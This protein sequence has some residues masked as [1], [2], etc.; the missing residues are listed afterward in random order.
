MTTTIIRNDTN[1][2]LLDRLICND[3]TLRHVSIRLNLSTRIR[4][5]HF[6][7]HNNHNIIPTGHHQHNPEQHPEQQQQQ[8]VSSSSTTTHPHVYYVSSIQEMIETVQT[9][10]P[11]KYVEEFEFCIPNNN[12][13][14]ID[15]D[16]DDEEEQDDPYSH[17][18]L[19]MMDV[20]NNTYTDDF[21]FLDIS[22]PIY[23]NKSSNTDSNNLDVVNDNNNI[24][25][26]TT[27]IHQQNQMDEVVDTSNHVG[28]HQDE[29][30]NET[31]G[32]SLSPSSS[33]ALIITPTS[34]KNNMK[35]DE[36]NNVRE[37][38]QMNQ[39]LTK[40]IISN[41]S[42][43]Y[44]DIWKALCDGILFNQSIEELVIGDI[45][46]LN[47]YQN[48]L[49]TN[50]C[51]IIGNLLYQ[52]DHIKKVTFKGLVIHNSKA[53]SIIS[54]SLQ[55]NTSIHIVQF[56]QVDL[57]R[58]DILLSSLSYNKSLK[59]LS[60]TDCEIEI[61]MIQNHLH[62]HPFYKLVSSTESQITMLK[63]SDCIIGS[64]EV[65]TLCLGLQ[66]NQSTIQVLDLSCNDL[67]ADSCHSISQML[68]TNQYIQELILEGN[69]MGDIGISFLSSGIT[70][71]ST[72]L[73]LN[74][75]SN[76]ITAK[77]CQYLMEALSSSSS[78][79][80]SLCQLQYLY[81]SE[82]DI[83][84]IGATY[85]GNMLQT[86][87]SLIML[88]LDACSFTDVGIVSIANGL[89]DNQTLTEINLSNNI[90]QGNGS[91]S[92]SNMLSKNSTL[93]SLY[94]SSCH[95]N[96]DSLKQLI[97]SISNGTNTTLQGLW[98]PFNNF[99]N[100]GIEYICQMIQQCSSSSS[101]LRTL[102]LQFNPFDVMIGLKSIVSVIQYNMSLHY[103]HIWND[104]CNNK[105]KTNNY[106]DLI[107]I[108][109][110]YLNLN[111][112]GRRGILECY[113]N[114]KDPIIWSH[115]LSRVSTIGG[116]DAIYYL[117]REVPT[118]TEK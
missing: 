52:T 15:D 7:R 72:L 67:V 114:S 86:N 108:M 6:L 81:L 42:N 43:Q 75:R 76:H 14:N 45:L 97:H 16:N 105:C 70:N 18:N 60:F 77:G 25:R 27:L 113:N 1:R 100:I 68:Q 118:L 24:S 11:N 66:S 32:V 53:I 50:V 106:N 87:T 89:C 83:G 33:T 65:S 31:N 96:N 13:C 73:K 49:H 54:Q 99:D 19:L 30:T 111:Q 59:F 88:E 8:F 84:N 64:Y 107:K 21:N 3:P 38:I 71:N 46:S 63:I 117:L 28:H 35:G 85:I 79:T 94:L 62:E 34:F 98:L 12:N 48:E 103:I 69:I 112:A 40:I 92:I 80:T 61:P 44:L 29:M 26:F 47:D 78:S 10:G 4:D 23:Y 93:Q 115:L 91:D 37:S 56:Q 9:I 2:T 109:D 41:L 39:S 104:G 102:G 36:Y 82:N 74:L 90:I 55:Y 51:S 95:I 58:Y 17:H 5:S 116:I 22:P 20:S 57:L 101:N 110:Y